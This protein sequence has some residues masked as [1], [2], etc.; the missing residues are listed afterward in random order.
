VR[1]EEGGE[2]FV[3]FIL[4]IVFILSLKSTFSETRR[5]QIRSM[6][7]TRRDGIMMGIQK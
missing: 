4:S 6:W 2:E 3:A 5:V 7:L 1:G